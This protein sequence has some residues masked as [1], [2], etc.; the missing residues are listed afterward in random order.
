MCRC[1]DNIKVTIINIGDVRLTDVNQCMDKCRIAMD[2]GYNEETA[3]RQQVILQ[4][5]LN[6]LHYLLTRVNGIR[7]HCIL[8]LE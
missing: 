5:L 8:F 4:K 1:V 2:V 3:L 7:C 6:F